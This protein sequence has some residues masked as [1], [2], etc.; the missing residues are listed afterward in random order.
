MRSSSPQSLDRRFPGNEPHHRW[1][2][3]R[4]ISSRTWTWLLVLSGLWLGLDLFWSSSTP[5]HAQ[6]T[7]ATSNADASHDATPT[8][9]GHADSASD[10]HHE[11]HAGGHADPAAP[12]L[13]AIIIVLF[14]AK[15]GGDLFERVKLPAVLGE[16]IVGVLLGNMALLTGWHGVDFLKAP[17]D[18]V[19][20]GAIEKLELHHEEELTVEEREVLNNPREHSFYQAGAI[21]KMLAAIGV[22]LLLFEVGLESS[23]KEMMAVGISSTIVAV[24]GVVAPMIL[25]YVVGV[26]IIPKAGWQVHSF[27]GATLCATSVGITARVLK[28]LGRSTQRESQ[29]ILGAAVIDDVLGLIV[30]AVVSGIIQQGA[31]FN[32]ASLVMIV[33]KAFGFLLGAIVLGNY[34]FTRPL[35]KAASYLRGHGLLVVTSLVICFGFSY[36][37]NL[38]G[39]ATIVGAFAAG[40]IL[41]KAHY[42]DLGHKENIELE[43][44]LQPL[45]AVLVPIFFVQM[46]IMVDL[47]S[48]KDPS[49]WG[50]AAALTFVAILGKQVCA[51]GVTEKGLNRLA[52]GLGMIPRG[53][54][55]LIFAAE[56]AKLKVAGEPVV[57]S[58]TYSAVVV[59]VML[60]TMITPP[61]LKWALLRGDAPAPDSSTDSTGTESHA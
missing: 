22:V 1:L 36:V 11:E 32:P 9:E 39:L 21:L 24:L 3:R 31:D 53:E 60:T 26:L 15:V 49:V 29:I 2:K 7:E 17:E 27:M 6:P 41:E 14:L 16:L 18:E 50:L 13:L 48:F 44:A 47:S 57:S 12:M 5:A 30:L 19:L 54:V 46:G 23:V 4:P 59:M 51:L 45:S 61:V 52:V 56:G 35:Y 43:E 55:G 37:A 58:G 38:M 34:I 25:G 28:D 10:E 40:L 20:Q 8:E 33:G 42:Q